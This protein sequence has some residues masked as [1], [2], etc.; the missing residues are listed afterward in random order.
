M[1]RTWSRSRGRLAGDSHVAR[2]P[3]ILVLTL[4]LAG[5]AIAQQTPG[6]AAGSPASPAYKALRLGGHRFV[7]STMI[8]DPFIR[9]SI[10]AS[11][12]AASTVA[13]VLPR[14]QLGNRDLAGLDGGIVAANLNLSYQ[15]SFHERMSVMFEFGMQGDLGT[16]KRSLILK[17]VT[18]ATKSKLG[19]LMRVWGNERAL[20]S[21]SAVVS[22]QSATVVDILGFVE[23]VIDSGG[24]TPDNTI[25]RYVPTTDG[26]GGVR[27]A[28]E[29]SPLVGVVASLES[30][31]G[32]S[33]DRETGSQW[34]TSGGGFLSLDFSGIH[35]IPLGLSV[36][37]F[38]SSLPGSLDETMD[39]QRV[40]VLGLGYVGRG[41]FDLG[42]ELNYQR[43]PQQG[44]SDPFELASGQ[45]NIRYYF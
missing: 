33:L 42:L 6:D 29:F 24:V 16:G 1:K 39:G 22:N 25:I 28:Y 40:I 26:R 12:G 43:N 4:G 32:E 17:G 21:A 14:V 23:G 34:F 11:L 15:Q 38:A 10:R 36:G 44:T 3:V 31:Y 35:S 37:G 2:W 18:A 13:L 30:G 9:T 5:S 27:F 7:P 20:L 41:D 19:W 8:P 45:L